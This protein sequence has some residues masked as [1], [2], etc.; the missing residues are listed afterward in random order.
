MP[1]K[2]LYSK[3]AKA[4]LDKDWDTAFRLYV[5]SAESFL[6]LSRLTSNETVRTKLKLNAGKALERAEKIK[7][8]KSGQVTPV[9]IDLFSERLCLHLRRK[10]L[11]T[12]IRT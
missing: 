8:I 4:E 10:L 5:K 1:D 2:A 9:V 6:H 7:A 11:A 12:E 3:A